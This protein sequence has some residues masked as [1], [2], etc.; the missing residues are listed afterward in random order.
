MDVSMMASC[1]RQF[2]FDAEE[3]KICLVCEGCKSA[4]MDKEL[5][6]MQHE[7]DG[8]PEVLRQERDDLER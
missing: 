1:F 7:A 2:S 5:A 6:E 4:T 8:L 3:C